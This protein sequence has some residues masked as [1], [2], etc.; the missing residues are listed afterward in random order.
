M[1]VLFFFYISFCSICVCFFCFLTASGDQTAHIWRYM[2]QLPLPQPPADIS[3]SV[4][5]HTVRILPPFCVIMLL[6]SCLNMNAEI[7]ITYLQFLCTIYSCT[8]M[9]FERQ[10]TIFQ[11]KKI[12]C[13]TSET[14]FP[15]LNIMFYLEICHSQ[16]VKQVMNAV[17]C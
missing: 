17:S 12:I 15:T 14:S 2:V 13:S 9:V 3:V 1:T 4:K 16:G 6:Q 10:K 5:T 11:E 7:N 8:S